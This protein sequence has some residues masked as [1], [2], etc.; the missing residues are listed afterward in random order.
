MI[1]GWKWSRKEKT[2]IENLV[3]KHEN[4]GVYFA[5]ALKTRLYAVAINTAC[6]YSTASLE[7]RVQFSSL[8]TLT[9]PRHTWW[10]SQHPDSTSPCNSASSCSIFH[11]HL[12]SSFP[13]QWLGKSTSKLRIWIKCVVWMLFRD[14][15]K[16]FRTHEET[17]AL[18]YLVRS[19]F[20]YH[21]PHKV[22]VMGQ[23]SNYFDYFH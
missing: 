2:Q 12:P 23:G 19:S 15:L 4:N 7:F 14:I 20:G 6:T 16:G 18:N 3:R 21:C 9:S 13:G 11:F 5:N 10:Q 1:W 8:V 22:F 17:K